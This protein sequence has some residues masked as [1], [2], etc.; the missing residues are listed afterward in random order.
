M[1]W[2]YLKQFLGFAWIVITNKNHQAYSFFLRNIITPSFHVLRDTNWRPFTLY[3]Y[4][5]LPT[6]SY[7][8]RC[9]RSIISRAF[10][11][12][13]ILFGIALS[14]MFTAALT[15]ALT[16]AFTSTTIDLTKKKVT[17][18]SHISFYTFKTSKGLLAQLYHTSKQ[19]ASQ[20]YFQNLNLEQIN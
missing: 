17:F 10:A 16:T 14:G 15:S 5:F 1:Q 13:W 19:C 20:D 3:K 12:L 4:I 6:N 8:D 11:V 2:T 18:P 7:G 9:P